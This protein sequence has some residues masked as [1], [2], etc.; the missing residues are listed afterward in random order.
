MARDRSA[1]GATARIPRPVRCWLSRLSWRPTTMTAVAETNDGA[2]PGVVPVCPLF[3]TCGGCQYQHL[4]YE[5]QLTLKTDE[6][7]RLFAALPTDVAP[8]VPSPAPYG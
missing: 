7:R 1:A 8:C 3:G 5:D 2:S 4:A 6:I